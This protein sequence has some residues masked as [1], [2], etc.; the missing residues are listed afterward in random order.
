MGPSVKGVLIICSNGSAPLNK[1]AAM[2]IYGTK[3]LK[4]IF[5]TKKAL[6]LNLGKR[7]RDS[8][9][10]KFVQMTLG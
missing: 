1:M 7:H 10:T 5:R 4:L 3:H 9:S 2:P 6:R 8:R